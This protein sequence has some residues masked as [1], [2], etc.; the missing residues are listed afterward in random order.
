MSEAKQIYIDLKIYA[1]KLCPNGNYLT[2]KYIADSYDNSTA[3]I[4]C[5]CG[6]GFKE[7]AKYQEYN[8]AYLPP[9]MDE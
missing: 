2:F 9:I 4:Q 5:D 3:Y 6:C 7:K 1:G 8:Y